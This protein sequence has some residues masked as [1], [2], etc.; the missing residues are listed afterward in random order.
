M[1]Q[2]SVLLLFVLVLGATAA[3]LANPDGHLLVITWGGNS[4]DWNQVLHLS[5]VRIGCSDAP[6]SCIQQ[7]DQLGASQHVS[8]VFLAIL[9]NP[10][11]V[12][13]NAATFGNL[14][15]SHPTLAE[16][17][18]D[19]F[20]S[21]CEKTHLGPGELSSLLETV[22]SNLKSRTSRVQ[23]GATIYQD[24]LVTGE[25]DRLQLSDAARGSVDLVH[26]FPHY[27]KERKSVTEYIA[28]AKRAFP[29]AKVIL[30]VYAYDRREYLPCSPDIHVACSNEEEIDLF[31]KVL[32]ED[33]R[34]ASSGGAVGIEFF[35]GNFGAEDAWKGWNNPR[36]CKQGE[37]DACV[38]NTV[39]MR[40][41]VREVMGKLAQ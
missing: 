1:K 7:V 5:G 19:D 16:V 10:A 40:Q 31:D 24:Q 13:T 36:A 32:R 8:S 38:Q 21:Q 41:K 27:R 22:A 23:F 12:A 34:I 29:N 4:P 37:R 20:V 2:K 17:G 28:E 18:F 3:V 39:A 26:L 14:A 25:L 6:A 15:L 33:L 35:P 9:L 11:N 30:G